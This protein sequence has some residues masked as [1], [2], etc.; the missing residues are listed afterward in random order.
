MREF[1]YNFFY[2]CNNDELKDNAFFKSLNFSFKYSC[3]EI[4]VEEFKMI[5][6]L[7]KPHYKMSL[8]IVK[9]LKLLNMK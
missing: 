5:E 6:N 7:K 3:Y 9:R 2:I 1:R 8:K 4:H